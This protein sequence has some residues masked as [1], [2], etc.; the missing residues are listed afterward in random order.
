M[1]PVFRNTRR[2]F[3]LFTPFLVGLCCLA[4]L[5][6]AGPISAATYYVRVN[7]TGDG[8][9]WETA[10]SDLAGI[11]NDVVVSGDQICV[12]EGAYK[13]T[14]ESSDRTASFFLKSG[15]A[16]YGGFP[17]T[18]DPDSGDRDPGS[19]IT[20]L[21]GDIDDNDSVDQYGIVVSADLIVASNSYH[22]VYAD[23]V[24]D[25]VLDG[26]VVTGGNANGSRLQSYGGGMYNSQSSPTVTNC[27]FSG[28]EAGDGGGMCNF[29]LSS[30]AVT[31]CTFSGN[32]AR[33]GGGVVNFDSS[34]QVTN[35]TFSGNEA[36]DS[37]G[38][39]HNCASSCAITNCTFSGNEAVVGHGLSNEEVSDPVPVTNC[40]FWNTVSNEFQGDHSFTLSYCLVRSG[41]VA[42]LYETNDS[43]VASG[44]L[45]LQPLADNGGPTMTCALGTGSIAIDAG[46]TVD[47]V[48]TDQ[49]G[50]ARPYPEGGSFDIGAFEVQASEDFDSGDSGC[51]ALPVSGLALLMLPLLGLLKKR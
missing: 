48:S 1:K 24:D 13:P 43:A 12:A 7:G 17:A 42:V 9:S 51:N 5:V 21:T 27:T 41:D 11:L 33:Y 38:G 35:C 2:S 15:V 8:L 30:P 23:E 37:G 46:V 22:V 50:A 31:N 47:G 19:Y 20:V 44:D 39:M 36:G 16:L 40:I 45:A 29:R 49:R 25:T 26:F 34:P 10:S 4:V 18:G 14:E 28:N 32:E 3:L 6:T